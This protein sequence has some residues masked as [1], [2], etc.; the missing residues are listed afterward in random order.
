M[1]LR[2]LSIAFALL[3][4]PALC[5]SAPYQAALQGL[6]TAGSKSMTVMSYQDVDNVYGLNVKKI[7]TAANPNTNVVHGR[8]QFAFMRDWDGD[9]L[10][11]ALVGETP[12]SSIPSPVASVKVSYTGPGAQGS[13]M[14][15][16]PVF[17]GWTLLADQGAFVIEA[18]EF[19]YTTRQYLIPIHNQ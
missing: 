17:T 9:T 7:L 15:G 8:N 14:L 11:S 13:L 5:Q 18:S 12:T 1:S 4:V 19:T 3:S 10:L 2:L 6:P 16:A